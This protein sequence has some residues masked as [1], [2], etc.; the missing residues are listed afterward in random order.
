MSV[1]AATAFLTVFSDKPTVRSQL[2][3]MNPRT[4]EDFLRF[5]HTKTGYSF[6]K[7]D[8]QAALAN[9]NTPSAKEVKERYKL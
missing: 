7:A 4:V 8:L 3:V 1:Q 6:S 2:Y 5:A 9:F